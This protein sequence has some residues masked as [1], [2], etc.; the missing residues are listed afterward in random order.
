MDGQ[1]P[2]SALFA[3]AVS[4]F[5]PRNL[6]AHAAGMELEQLNTASLSAILANWSVGMGWE[7]MPRRSSFSETSPDG[8][9]RELKALSKCLR[10]QQGS[11]L[12]QGMLS[13]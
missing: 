10:A 6:D 9:A 13:A 2:T 4:R 8:F 11:R 12:V 7:L 1:T 3:S 5:A